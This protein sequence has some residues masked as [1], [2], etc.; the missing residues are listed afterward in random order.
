MPLE[1]DIYLLESCLSHTTCL[2]IASAPEKN[3]KSFFN[4]LEKLEY[5]VHSNSTQPI[6]KSQYAFS[7]ILLS[8]AVTGSRAMQLN[9]KANASVQWRARKLS[10]FEKTKPNQTQPK[11]P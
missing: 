3:Y 7:Y 9:N 5:L 11:S 2:L 6:K 8:L 4:F 10:C 1:L